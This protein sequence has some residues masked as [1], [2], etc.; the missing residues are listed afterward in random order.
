MCIAACLPLPILAVV[1]GPAKNRDLHV[2]WRPASVVSLCRTQLVLIDDFTESTDN[3]KGKSNIFL[4]DGGKMQY[5]NVL[6]KKPPLQAG[7]SACL[8]FCIT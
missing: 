4:K 6:E 5:G 1:P 8:Y 2:P 7:W 3:G